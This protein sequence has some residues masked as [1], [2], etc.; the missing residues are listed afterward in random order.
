MGINNSGKKV[1]C[2]Q[3][4]GKQR[5][6]RLFG[7]SSKASGLVSGFV[8]LKPEESVGV[9]NTKDKEEALIILQGQA[10]ISYSKRSSIE[11]KKNSFVYIPPKMDHD[12]RNTG[13]SLLKY[14]YLTA[15]V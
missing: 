12:V 10:K 7:E 15:N 6:L 5:F 1:F 8:V 4:K 9:H 14:V 13:K 11:V 3:L 2:M